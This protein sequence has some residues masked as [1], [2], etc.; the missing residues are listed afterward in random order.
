M[1]LTMLLALLHQ[2]LTNSFVLKYIWNII[3][4]VQIVAN[5]DSGLDVDKWVYFALDCYFLGVKNQFD[6]K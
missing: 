1:Y 3:L 4:T 2:K 5:K 6:L